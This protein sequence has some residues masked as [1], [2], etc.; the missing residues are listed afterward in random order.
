MT[1]PSKTEIRRFEL[2]NDRWTAYG[3]HAGVEALSDKLSV[4]EMR[5]FEIFQ[6]YDDKFLQRLSPD[7]SLAVWKEKTVLFEEGSYLDIA[8]FIVDG[9]V[10][11]YLE[12]LEGGAGPVF[13][14]KRTMMVPAPIAAQ[15]TEQKT[16][17]ARAVELQQ[18]APA[19]QRSEIAF[20]ATLDFDLPKGHRARLE[21][22][23]LFGEIG[24]LS[25]WP[26]SVTARTA[27]P[28]QLI[29][30]RMPALR[31]MRRKSK[32][33]KERLDRIYRDRALAT[34]LRSTPLLKHCPSLFIEGLKEAVELISCD[35]GERIVA[36][37]EEVNGLYLVRSGFV[38]LTQSFGEGELNVTYL[39]KG[40][41]FGEVELLVDG[42]RLWETS[43]Y[44]VEYA[45]LVKIPIDAFGTLLSDD[46]EAEE[47]LWKSVT[48]RVKEIGHSRRNLTQAELI[49]V[50]LDNGLVEGTSFLAID[51][52]RCTRCDD[53]VRACAATHDGRPR[54]V[55]EGDKVSNLLIARSCYHCRDPVCLVGC[56][57]GAIHRAGAETVVEIDE[58]ICI[59]C[60]TC[61]N[62][63]PYDAIMMHP[64]GE[65][66][67]D[68]AIPTGLRGRD[69]QVASKC[70]LCA[71]T[72]HD[73]AC[74]TNCPQ[75]CAFRIGS[76]D[77]LKEHLSGV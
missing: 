1:V 10:D 53:C 27:T 29:Q 49:Q 30:I 51:L 47:I 8:F 41:T 38:R 18:Q 48:A 72:G 77:E 68:N 76:M 50:G 12:S 64:T 61:A 28:C 2:Y 6:D 63:C 16:M 37:G 24:A 36:E 43:A 19:R 69:R 17:I 32:A 45:E 22:G 59:G 25:G 62:N 54:F 7:V 14:E 74:V 21:K 70:D 4:A 9:E 40:M 65:K 52:E 67:P 55:R 66:W 5:Q 60:S 26:Q 23:E 75:G 15:A 34:Q 44:S 42:L 35:P 20:L 46:P 73:P 33:L 71:D 58:G 57:T 11:L 31:L 56:P 3:D 39:S 13:D